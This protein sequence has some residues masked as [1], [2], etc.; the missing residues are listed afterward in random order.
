[1]NLQTILARLRLIDPL[2]LPQKAYSQDGEDLVLWRMLE[3]RR[4]GFFVDVGAHHPYRFSNTCLLSK[5]GWRGINIDAE[6]GSM[7]AFRR[8]RPRDIN[9]ECGVGL[10]AGTMLYYRFNEPALNTFSPEEAQRKNAAPYRIVETVE[11]E[12]RPLADI[13]DQ[14]LPNS[15]GIDILSVD[16]EGHDLNVLRSNNWSKYRPHIVL[17]ETLRTSLSDLSTCPTVSFMGEIGYKPSSKVYN[18]VLFTDVDVP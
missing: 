12:V 4:D 18:T 14:Y 8:H 1:M 5:A 7:A 17:A 11:L 3:G 13:L 10:Q 9:L 2:K 16:A 15:T 6:P